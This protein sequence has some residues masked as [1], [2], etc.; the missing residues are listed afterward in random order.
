MVSG[1]I[2]IIFIYFLF[3]YYFFYHRGAIKGGL[4]ING[5]IA[6][7]HSPNSISCMDKNIGEVK[8]TVTIIY[9]FRNKINPRVKGGEKK[10]VFHSSLSNKILVNR[11]N[12]FKVPP[13]AYSI[14]LEIMGL[15]LLKPMECFSFIMFC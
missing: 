11:L 14:F 8:P 9:V 7:G 4:S 2:I 1:I 13:F 10:R 12:I 15:I 6:I 5:F 3:F